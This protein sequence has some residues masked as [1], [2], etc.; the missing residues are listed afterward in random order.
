MAV[1]SIAVPNLAAYYL[2]KNLGRK[3][4]YPTTGTS[5]LQISENELQFSHECP[6]AGQPR[7]GRPQPTR[8]AAGLGA[9]DGL[10][11]R[12]SWDRRARPA[13]EVMEAVEGYTLLRTD[14]NGWVE[15]T[16]DGEQMW[17][18]VKRKL[19]QE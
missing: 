18:E 16:M 1:H 19:S 6:A 5:S 13:P 8:V 14:Q 3:V 17:V 9:A 10:A 4:C 12:E 11:Q 2:S 15:L 7:R